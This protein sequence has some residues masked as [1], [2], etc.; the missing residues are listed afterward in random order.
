[1][2]R[3]V[4][5]TDWR[6]NVI[7]SSQVWTTARDLARLGLIYLNDGVWNQQRI[8]PADW[9]AYVSLHADAQPPAGGY[10]Y[11]AGFWNL[12]GDSGR[13]QDAYIGERKSVWLKGLLH[14]V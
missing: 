10:G 9:G 14:S 8:L 2:T 3:T 11:G 12:P 5:E 4:P 6:G 7:L 13:P 1:M